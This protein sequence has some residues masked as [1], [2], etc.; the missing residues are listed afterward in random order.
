MKGEIYNT[1]PY[2]KWEAGIV[3]NLY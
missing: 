3:F 2:Q 1:M